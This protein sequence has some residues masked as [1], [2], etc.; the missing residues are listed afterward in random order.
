M[1]DKIL[2]NFGG[3]DFMASLNFAAESKEVLL[4]L[5]RDVIQKSHSKRTFLERKLPE[6]ETALKMR[7]TFAMMN[8]ATKKDLSTDDRLILLKLR[9]NSK[10][11]G[12]FDKDFRKAFPKEYGINEQPS[13]EKVKQPLNPNL[14]RAIASGRSY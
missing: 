14:I 11:F 4:A 8:I 12:D 1:T 9:Y 5:A 3:K 10:G 13:P 6:N 2:N 7:A